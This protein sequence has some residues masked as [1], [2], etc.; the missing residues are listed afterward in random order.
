MKITLTGWFGY[1]FLVASLLATFSLLFK[2]MKDDWTAKDKVNQTVVLIVLA[3][4]GA[5]IG[6]ALLIGG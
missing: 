3:V 6:G 2:S 5:M 1:I 4:L